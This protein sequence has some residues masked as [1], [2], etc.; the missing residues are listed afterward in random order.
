[1]DHQSNKLK[2]AAP[3]LQVEIGPEKKVYTYVGVVLASKCA[4]AYV[5]SLLAHANERATNAAPD[6]SRDFSKSLGQ[7]DEISRGRRH[8]HDV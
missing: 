7:N 4:Y 3:D 8:R 6:I 5:D 2:C 1:M